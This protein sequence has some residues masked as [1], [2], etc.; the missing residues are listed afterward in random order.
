MRLRRQDRIEAIRRLSAKGLSTGEIGR[1]VETS[2]P[3]VGRLQKFYGI[4]P[5]P[6]RWAW[7]GELSQQQRD[8]GTAR[9]RRNRAA[10]RTALR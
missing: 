10:K 8:Q 5:A 9:R 6:V 2:G 7:W 1:L 4:E 3:N